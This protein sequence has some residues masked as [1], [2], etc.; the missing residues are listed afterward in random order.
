MVIRSRRPIYDRIVGKSPKYPHTNFQWHIKCGLASSSIEVI[1]QMMTSTGLTL[2]FVENDFYIA[3]IIF[4]CTKKKLSSGCLGRDQTL[5]L[6]LMLTLT[7]VK[8][9]VDSP[10]KGVHII[11]FN[12][13]LLLLATCLDSWFR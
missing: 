9:Y 5:T 8:Q 2:T 4:W 1:L 12:V 6:M 13:C 11:T 10:L 7:A 3:G